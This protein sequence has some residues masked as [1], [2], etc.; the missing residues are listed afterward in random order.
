MAKVFFLI[1]ILWTFFFATMGAAAECVT[2]TRPN[3]HLA[4][5]TNKICIRPCQSAG[6]SGMWEITFGSDCSGPQFEAINGQC[7]RAGGTFEFREGGSALVTATPTPTPTPVPTAIPAPDRRETFSISWHCP[8]AAGAT[9]DIPISSSVSFTYPFTTSGK[10]HG[11][12]DWENWKRL[13]A[14]AKNSGTDYFECM[15]LA[16][17]KLM[18]EVRKRCVAFERNS[19]TSLK[20]ATA[21][22]SSVIK[23]NLL[24]DL[25]DEQAEIG[26]EALER[27]ARPNFLPNDSMGA[28]P[29][30]VTREQVFA[31]ITQGMRKNCVVSAVPPEYA[32]YAYS[33]EFIQ[34][35]IT[36]SGETPPRGLFSTIK[37]KNCREKI[38]LSYMD[39]AAQVQ[40]S[41]SQCPSQS[42]D[43]ICVRLKTGTV[44][45]LEA[46]RGLDANLKTV[47]SD[48]VIA[49]LNLVS[50][51]STRA[52]DLAET[53]RDALQC[54]SLAVGEAKGIDRPDSGTGL[55]SKYRL[56]KTGEKS[57]VAQL[58][59]N[60][61]TAQGQSSSTLNSRYRGKV[62]QCL[63]RVNGQLKG[64][65][66]QSLKIELG[67][68]TGAAAAPPV[69]IRIQSA[70]SRSNSGN[71]ESD[72]RCDTVLHELLHLLGLVDEYEEK[73]IGYTTDDDGNFVYRESSASNDSSFYNC[74]AQGPE[75]SIMSDHEQAFS[76]SGFTFNCSEGSEAE[77]DACDFLPAAP[78][79]ADARSLLETAHFNAIVN[80]GCSAKNKTY[81]QCAQYAYQT[82]RDRYGLGCKRGSRPTQC[83]NNS[84]SWV[85]R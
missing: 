58:N 28:L 81:Y 40:P 22:C 27:N 10:E 16:T 24:K 23:T 32:Y 15:Y 47:L 59:L 61:K 54:V 62:T 29:P 6:S 74:R 30:G 63:N 84:T 31:G 13:I 1:H 56:K 36:P 35:F 26:Q 80:P 65:D 50:D 57:F 78:T 68:Q 14:P 43:P 44:A 67:P 46:V 8:Q 66:G 52:K 77:S 53:V 64:P 51:P 75:D 69:S 38:M 45:L 20:S 72:I 41:R 33:A 60:F 37:D 7:V 82:T 11:P 2:D 18:E 39:I 42:S 25:L 4:F 48:R 83:T 55:G 85:G 9:H 71:W 12:L 73:L 49:C 17:M 79:D 3:C 21:K 70:D 5:A 76:E 34:Q 19:G